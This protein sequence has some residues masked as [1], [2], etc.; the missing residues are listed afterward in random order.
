MKT[1]QVFVCCIILTISVQLQAQSEKIDTN[2][3]IGE[4]QLDM[5]PENTTDA[6]FA[7]MIITKVNNNELKGSF[8]RDGVRIREG[9]I[10]TQTGIIYGALVSGDNSGEYNTSFY[11]KNGKLYG[12]THAIGRAFLA[13]WTATK[14]TN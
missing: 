1:I 5:S 11:Y 13:V 2:V 9:R 12:S 10:N 7:K 6:N 3:L 4:W 14:Q 8:Y